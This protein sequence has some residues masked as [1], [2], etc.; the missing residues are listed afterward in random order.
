[1]PN[2]GLTTSCTAEKAG[3]AIIVGALVMLCREALVLCGAGWSS[4]LRLAESP[5]A[6]APPELLLRELV[7]GL[8]PT[9]GNR[10]LGCERN[11][12][13]N[14]NQTKKIRTHYIITFDT[15]HDCLTPFLSLFVRTR[16]NEE[17]TLGSSDNEAEW[18]VARGADLD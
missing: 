12:N 4:S 11:H 18:F 6:G 16:C 3:L 8:R 7:V 13:N 10:V 9:S 5:T 15:R 1:M 17:L 14:N 2:A